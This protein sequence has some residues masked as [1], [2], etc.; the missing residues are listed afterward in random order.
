MGLMLKRRLKDADLPPIFSPHRFRVLAVTDLLFQ[1]VPPEDVQK[2]AGHANP[3]PRRSMN[4]GAG[5]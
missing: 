3:K 4:V 1:D 2:L 5:G